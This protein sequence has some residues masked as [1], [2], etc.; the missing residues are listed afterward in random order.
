MIVGQAIVGH[1]HRVVNPL[2][3]PAI[4]FPD[5]AVIDGCRSARVMMETSGLVPA[6]PLFPG[7]GSAVPFETTLTLACA[8]PSQLGAVPGQATRPP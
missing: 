1:R 4:L 3:S 8:V 5:G 6:G 7:A 2:E